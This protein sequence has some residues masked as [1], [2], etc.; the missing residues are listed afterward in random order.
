MS[1]VA[2]P[3]PLSSPFLAKLE[4]T[5]S[6]NTSPSACKSSPVAN[7]ARA[8]KDDI[9]VAVDVSLEVSVAVD[10]FSKNLRR[11]FGSSAASDNLDAKPKSVNLTFT[12]VA[13]FASRSSSVL[14]SK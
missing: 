11:R 3:L 12:A 13:F 7:A 5:S 14:S 9:D 2:N 6:R 10:V 4:N 8:E 1:A